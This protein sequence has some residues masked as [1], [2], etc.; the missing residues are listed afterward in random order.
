MSVRPSKFSADQM[1][2]L[3]IVGLSAAGLALW[4]YYKLH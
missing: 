4:R 1:I 3:L 2:L